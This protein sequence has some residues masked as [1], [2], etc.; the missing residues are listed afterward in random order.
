MAVYLHRDTRMERDLL[1]K[2]NVA[3]NKHYGGDVPPDAKERIATE[4]RHIIDSGSGTRLAVAAAMAE[5]SASHG[6]PVGVRGLVGNLL[7]SHLLG[8]AALDPLELGLPWEGFLGPDGSRMQEITLN[9][10]PELLNGLRAHLR[11]LFPDCDILFGPGVPS[12]R[13][14]IV[15]RAT[16][17]YDP[18]SEYLSITLC[19][20]E[21]MSLAGEVRRRAGGLAD[22]GEDLIVSAYRTDVDGIPVL[23]D[24]DG[25]QD[26]ANLLEPKSFLDLVKIMG[27]CLAWKL[28][29]QAYK[30]PLLPD[31][32]DHLI[33]TRED[34]YDTCLRHGVTKDDAFSIM[35]QAIRGKLSPEHRAMLAAKGVSATFLETLDKADYLYPRGQCADYLYWALMLLARERRPCRA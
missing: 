10:A 21:L 5:Y 30:I 20:H 34:I 4:T 1:D 22:F 9:I 8:I 2:I 23:G 33:G 17:P 7:V 15:P 29:F 24:L 28:Q 12:K 32:F 19:P 14:V 11:E 16:G 35:Q 18:D 6:Y 31:K 27:L 25:F 13:T 3:A 26:L